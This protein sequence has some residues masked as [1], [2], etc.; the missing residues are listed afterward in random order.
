MAV[1]LSL[2]D[3]D[4]HRSLASTY[5]RA[6]DNQVIAALPDFDN[7][8]LT[9]LIASLPDPWADDLAAAVAQ[10]CFTA[11]LQ[12][13]HRDC[14]ERLAADGRIDLL[15]SW[16]T[17]RNVLAIDAVLVRSNDS[18]AERRLLTDYRDRQFPRLQYGGTDADWIPNIHHSEN[19]NLVIEALRTMLRRG[20]EVH[21]IEPLFKATNRTLGEAALHFYDELIADETI[22]DASFLW[23][24]LQDCIAYLATDPKHDTSG[25]VEQLLR[26]S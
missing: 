8:T 12:D 22:P 13:T 23:Y 14:A 20:D 4:Q 26:D 11:T 24:R 2:S 18:A 19:A 5:D 6:W 3:S 21:E 9:Y 15:R 25:T 1:E 16:A 17:S 7:R 10:R